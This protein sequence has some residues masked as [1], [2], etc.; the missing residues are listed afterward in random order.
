MKGVNLEHQLKSL[1]SKSQQRHEKVSIS[2]KE[3]LKFGDTLRDTIE[4]VNQISTQADH[5]LRGL[6]A[7]PEEISQE[8]AQ[9]GNYHRNIMEAQHNLEALYRKYQATQKQ[10]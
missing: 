10:S 2:E 4:Q 3:K 5:A 8:F 7:T 6:S 9:A 1:Y